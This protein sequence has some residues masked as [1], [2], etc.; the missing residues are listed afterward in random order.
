MER[1]LGFDLRIGTDT[2]DVGVRYFPEIW[3]KCFYPA[4]GASLYIDKDGRKIAFN[5]PSRKSEGFQPSVDGLVGC[6]PLR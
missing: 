1:S 2:T 4:Q 3:K 5:P 6:F